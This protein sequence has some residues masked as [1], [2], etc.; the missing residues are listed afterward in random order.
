[1]NSFWLSSVGGAFSKRRHA[2]V[3]R[4]QRRS[5]DLQRGEQLEER[6][7]MAFDFVSAFP[8]AGQF[9]TPNSTLQEAPQQITLRF[10]PGAKI[11]ANTLGA[12]SI[13]RSG[14]G[15]DPV[16]GNGNDVAMTPTGGVGIVAVDDFPNQNQVVL[17]FAETLPDDVYRITI[18]GGLKTEAVG[19]TV[20]SESFRN[21]ASHTL[22]F[23]LDLGA[24]RVGPQGS[25]IGVEEPA[26]R[27]LALCCRSAGG[28]PP[29]RRGP[30]GRPSPGR[31]AS[32]S[33]PA[34][35][36]RPG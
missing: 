11:D 16:F 4:R 31:S 13:V 5:R 15:S 27:K 25:N 26:V 3:L 32:R 34:G 23:R 21:G 29:R 35:P 28:F 10:S 22:D 20:P 17:R 1:M 33:A 6:R 7:V 30:G 9:I 24:Q 2:A 19:K 18:G 8:N 36:L 14:S 12:I